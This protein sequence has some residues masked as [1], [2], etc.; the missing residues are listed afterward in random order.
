MSV[1]EILASKGRDV[2][3]ADADMTIQDISN[4]L[5]T[6]KIGATVVLDKSGHVC[7]IASERDLV[8]EIAKSGAD[9]LSKPISIC[10]TQKVVSCDE[11]ETIDGLMEKMTKGRFRHLPVI[12]NGKLTGIISIGDVVKR[13]IEQAEREAEEMKRYIAG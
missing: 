5:A 13:K 6:K 4:V 10:M 9:A 3:T 12:S 11:T 2:F 7:G 1:S 8:R